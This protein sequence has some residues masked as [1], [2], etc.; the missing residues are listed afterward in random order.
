MKL[1][2]KRQRYFEL[3]KLCVGAE[4]PGWWEIPNG[5]VYMAKSWCQL[6]AGSSVQ[7]TSRVLSSSPRGPL[8][9]A[10]WASAQHRS[11]AL[12]RNVPRG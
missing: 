5:L 9:I 4:T 8:P 2:Y 7:V 3:G 1:G 6:T 12:K 10:A 11:W